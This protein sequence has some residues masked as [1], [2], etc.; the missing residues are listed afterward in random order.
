VLWE[1][2][3]GRPL[4]ARD[5]DLETTRA[6]IE[7]PIARPSAVTKVPALLEAIIMCALSRDPPDR[8]PS[9]HEMAAA[10]ERY[11]LQDGGA[12][13][14]DLAGLMKTHFGE[15]Q[16]AWRRTVHMALTIESDGDLGRV[17][18][19][20]AGVKPS[21]TGLL[22]LL[23]PVAL[24]P[25]RGWPLDGPRAR[26]FGRLALALLVMAAIAFGLASQLFR[27]VQRPAP[28]AA[29]A[30]P[31]PMAV[32]PLPAPAMEYPI[33]PPLPPEAV[34]PG[35]PAAYSAGDRSAAPTEPR[36][37]EPT[38]SFPSPPAPRLDTGDRRPNPF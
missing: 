18:A 20:A 21:H 9:A 3:C 13:S 25:S 33:G 22:P 11:L 6:V 1:A 14:S 2:V 36:L 32:V 15:D 26:S 24:P 19:A 30:R 4:F 31:R 16:L 7:A 10:L 17:A 34:A 27:R 35:A 12:G 28:V 8:F 23:A 38:S 5:T 37:P 29:P